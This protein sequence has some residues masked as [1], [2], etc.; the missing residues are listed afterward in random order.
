[1]KK[2]QRPTIHCRLVST[3]MPMTR[4]SGLLFPWVCLVLFSLPSLLLL[5]FWCLS[6]EGI[7][8]RKEQVCTFGFCL[9]YCDG[10]IMNAN[11][12]LCWQSLISFKKI[13]THFYD[14]RLKIQSTFA[15]MVFV[16]EI[17]PVIN[18]D[19]FNICC[20]SGRGKGLVV[21][22]RGGVSGSSSKLYLIV[23]CSINTGVGDATLTAPCVPLYCS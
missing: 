14:L 12:G 18:A 16:Q 7:A 20:S 9:I 17:M 23:I 4:R 8:S 19:T 11:R 13:Y 5:Y 6:V 1:M 2:I 21:G 15:L 22:C 10:N 3:Q